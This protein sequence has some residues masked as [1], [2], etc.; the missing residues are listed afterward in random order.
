V[1]RV[2]PKYIQPDKTDLPSSPAQIQANESWTVPFPTDPTR[3]FGGN[4][5]LNWTYDGKAQPPFKFRI[6]G[7]NPVFPTIINYISSTVPYWFGQKIALHETNMSQF[8]EHGRQDVPDYCNQSANWSFPVY[9]PPAGYGVMQQ[10]PTPG[11]NDLWNWHTGVDNGKK[12]ADAKAAGTY[13]YWRTQVNQWNA[14]NANQAPSARVS[15][16]LDQNAPLKDGSGVITYTL[17][18]DTP[19]NVNTRSSKGLVTAPNGANNTY[20]F[21]DAVLIKQY[22]GL[23]YFLCPLCVPGLPDPGRSHKSYFIYQYITW[24][25]Q[26]GLQPYWIIFKDNTISSDVVGEVSSC[27]GPPRQ[28]ATYPPS[29]FDLPIPQPNR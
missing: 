12:V 1:G 5:S 29:A 20:W 27:Q 15:P 17:P 3:F 11:L 19:W 28:C 25:N 21:G 24:V 8:C 7:T 23:G 16:P 10:D 13:P 26:Q 6:C 14:Y 18:L 9:G 4:A 22:G 2:C